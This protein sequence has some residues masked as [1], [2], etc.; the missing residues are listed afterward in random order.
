MFFVHE[1]HALH[2]VQA[3][4]FETALREQWVPAL[5]QDERTRLVWCVRSMPAAISFP[6]MITLTAVEDG[7]AL[8]RLGERMRGRD[9]RGPGGE[10][11]QLRRQVTTR[12]LAPLEEFNPYQLDLSD[13]PLTRDDAPT[14]MYIHD[15]VVPQP[16]MQRR[17]EIQMR[18]AF[19]TMLDLEGLQMLIWAGLETV[20][21]GGRTPLSLMLTHIGSA[22]A[23]ANLL[24]EG[25]PRVRPEPGTWMHEGLQ[26]RDTWVSRLVRSVPWSPTS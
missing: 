15:F 2:P 10:L 19:M 25:N 8:E 17:Y 20:A 16:A 5:A 1:I 26:L 11:G 22:A 24:A 23:G 14:R 21:G 12:V 9:L 7:A 4:E 6:E 18:E 13:L 3:D